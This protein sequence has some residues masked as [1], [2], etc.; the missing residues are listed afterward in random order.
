VGRREERLVDAVRVSWIHVAGGW[1]EYDRNARALEIAEG[2][3]APGVEQRLDRGVRMLLRVVD[4]R[5][6]VHGGDAVV[7]LGEPAEQLVDVDVLGTV[8]RREG[9]QAQLELG[10]VTSPR[11]RTG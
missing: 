2:G 9:E 8:L 10:R 5:H 6:V 7:E 4:L 11:A 3:T 1:R